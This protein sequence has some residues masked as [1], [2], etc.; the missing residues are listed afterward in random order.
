MVR[1]VRRVVSA[2]IRTAPY[3]RYSHFVRS[4]APP[5]RMCQPCLARG[6]AG[7][8]STVEQVRWM[9][10]RARA[11]VACSWKRRC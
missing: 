7:Y 11:G 3:L 10:A 5:V 4:G 1:V 9:E 8:S 2:R 6:V